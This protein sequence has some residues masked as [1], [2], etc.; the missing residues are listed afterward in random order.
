MS[1]L[2]LHDHPD[3]GETRR[4][5]TAAIAIVLAHA[6]VIALALNWYQRSDPAGL[7]LQ[8]I[9]VELAP[10]PAAPRIQAE[11]QP[12]GPQVQE[13][14]APPVE[15][16][17]EQVIEEQL[18]PTPL[19]PQPVVVARPKI[20]PKPEPTP[21]KPKPVRER[22]KK[23][24][25]ERLAEKSTAA[26]ADRIAPDA[27]SSASNASAAA[28][29][30]ASYNSIVVSHLQRFKRYPSGAEARGESGR[31]SVAFTVSRN[32]RVTGTRLVKSSGFA[33][34]DQEA[35]AWIQRAQPLPP[36]PD[37]MREA[38]LMLTAPLSWQSR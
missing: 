17:I 2:A 3:Q 14:E 28:A 8:P 4:Y 29:A 18:Q 20:E 33:S 13:A 1:V 24:I 10:A 19:Q 30:R 34:L 22:E 36:F 26:K 38:T 9:M 31:A 5:G 7:S 35:I 37:E 27:P 6:A 23:P 16:P 12:P 11:D 32:G 21:V 25:K 15:P